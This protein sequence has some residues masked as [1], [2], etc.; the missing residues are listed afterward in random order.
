MLAMRAADY[1]AAFLRARGVRRVFGIPGGEN[2]DLIEALRRVDVTYVLAHHE[3]AAGHMAAATAQPSR[4]PGV[5][6]VTRGPGATNLYPAIATAFLD[7][8]PVRQNERCRPAG[9]H[10]THLSH[11][12]ATPRGRPWMRRSSASRRPADRWSSPGSAPRNSTSR[13]RSS[14]WSIGWPARRW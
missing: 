1:C 12:P 11:G 2:V 8:R 13:L 4:V 3:A 7:R 14:G 5:C 9:R 6:I 10:Q